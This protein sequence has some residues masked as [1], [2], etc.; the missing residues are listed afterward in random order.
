[1]PRLQVDY[2]IPYKTKKYEKT[3]CNYYHIVWFNP[4]D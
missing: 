2:W 3:V 4:G 1:M